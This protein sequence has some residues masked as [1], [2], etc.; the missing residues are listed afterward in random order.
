M[1]CK[2]QNF[3]GRQVVERGFQLVIDCY[4]PRSV[5]S[6]IPNCSRPQL[7]QQ[8]APSSELALHAE[9][10]RDESK[11]AAWKGR[12][13]GRGILP[14]NTAH[15][16]QAGAGQGCR[17]ESPRALH[18]GACR[19]AI[20]EGSIDRS[21]PQ[22]QSREMMAKAVAMAWWEWTGRLTSE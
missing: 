18:A 12:S 6:Q 13:P 2:S 10:R 7:S 21:V 15:S 14:M 22:L 8:P 16:T 20:A 3:E 17:A 11:Q 5:A 9:G 4:V 1:Q 19:A